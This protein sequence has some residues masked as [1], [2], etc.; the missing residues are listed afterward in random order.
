MS[1][2]I[3]VGGIE[4][5][6]TTFIP[7]STPLENFARRTVRGDS[8]LERGDANTIVDGFVK[9]VGQCGM[10]VVPLL[11]AKGDSGG[12][13]SRATFETLAHDLLNCLSQS[14]PVDGVLLSLHGSFAAEGFDDGDGE[15]LRRVREMVGTACPIMAVHDLH[16]NIS[17]QMVEMAD[18]LMIERT[19]P[20]VD[21]AQRAMEGAHLMARTL[22]AEVR[23]TMAY[24]SLPLLWAA[25]K[26]IDAEVPMSDAVMQL[27]RF[28]EKPGVLSAS[29][30]VG[31]QWID[32]PLVGASTIVVT[33]DNRNQAVELAD[34]LAGWIW[35]RR[36]DWQRNSLSPES[37]LQL[38][39]EA[40]RYPIVLADQGDNTGGGAPGD[41]TELL[42][43]F[44][45]RDL[46]Q[47]AVLYMIDP[48]AAELVHAAGVGATVDVQLGGKSHPLL[49][50]PV[51]MQVEV[52]S[53]SD[54]CFTYDGPMWAGVKANL[55]KS[56]L[57]RQRG[58][59]VI[60]TSQRAQPMDLAFAR[61][62]GLDCRRMRYICVKSTGHF[63]SGFEPIAG[64]I[65]NVDSASLLSQNFS[66]LPYT[67]LGRKMYPLHDDASVDWSRC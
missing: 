14:L 31:Y 8:L 53:L 25:P 30:G 40:G 42:R 44:L 23:P 17:S 11:W 60:V 1:W 5:E 51:S 26:M 4:H 7:D 35:D 43:L 61:T 56:A 33:D 32:N 37:A 29:I 38:G 45:E 47:A 34:E 64:S 2:R 50:P 16:S 15:I 59:H 10:Q 12:P 62:L 6:T 9:G 41:S 58:V 19:Y 63:R 52:L 27:T 21:M 57:L 22:A 66:Q 13:A 67:R 39:E 3:A 49:G 54:G 28:D 18:V 55:G 20:H 24:R 36:A 48:E 65:H 46:Q